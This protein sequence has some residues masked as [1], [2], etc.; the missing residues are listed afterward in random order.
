M[1]WEET[2]KHI[3]TQ[4][5]FA[6]LVDKAYFSADLEKNISNFEKS[7]EFLATLKIIEE[8]APNAKSIL[9][10]GSG[11]GISAIN[12]AKVGYNV[13]ALEPDP[14]KT[15]GAG[16]INIVK[17][18]LKLDNI[19][20]VESYAEDMGFNE[21]IFDVVYVRQAVH[22]ANDLNSF[23]KQCVHVLKPNGLLLTVRDHVVFN[24]EDKMWFLESH[25]LHKFYGGE[26]AF[27]PSEYRNAIKVAGAELV[28]ELKYYDN[29]INYF[30]LS[31]KD[32]LLQESNMISGEKKRLKNKLGVLYK[33][34]FV[35]SFY[36]LFRGFNALD[37][38]KV[39]GR[40]YSYI[41]L[42]K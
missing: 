12:F 28:K 30:P 15:V 18:T 13:V 9:D 24:K 32:V 25:P 39:P 33:V 36:K 42:K 23:I 7:E 40:M 29:I 17:D 27:S 26:N 35:W 1:T 16:A 3:R 14:S 8:Y 6:E 19:D 20:V 34:P 21:T 5:E 37:E 10:I 2:I 31:K 22:H 41:A 38:T 11:N 4:P